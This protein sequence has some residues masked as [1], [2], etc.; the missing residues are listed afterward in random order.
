MEFSNA[1]FNYSELRK[2]INNYLN[3][4]EL[5]NIL[6]IGSYEGASSCYFSDN[7]LDHKDSTLTC[8]DPFDTKD[9]TSE[10]YY[11]IKDTFIKNITLS[12]NYNKI[13]LHETTSDEFFKGNVK[14]YN[15][16]YIDGSHIIENIIKDLINAIKYCKKDGIIWMDDYLGDNGNIKP[17]IDSFYEEYKYFIGIVH[18][19]YQIAFKKLN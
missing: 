12:K 19:G 8:I 1:W 9:T 17:F 2:N 13:T 3:N 16:I 15:F 18:K 4:E 7:F 10:V 11:N 6:E 14:M 5:N